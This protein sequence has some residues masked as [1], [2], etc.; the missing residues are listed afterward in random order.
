MVTKLEL[1]ALAPPWEEEPPPPGE[2]V[3]PEREGEC[4]DGPEPGR[5]APTARA[6]EIPGGGPRP[7]GRPGGGT[8]GGRE[9]GSRGEGERVGV[10][11]KEERSRERPRGSVEE[12]KGKE[13]GGRLASSFFS[14]EED[15]QNGAIRR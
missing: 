10:G 15:V 13:E 9:E 8:V 2:P 5:P 11:Q 12:K 3:W 7:G 4:E 14:V 1:L 6:G